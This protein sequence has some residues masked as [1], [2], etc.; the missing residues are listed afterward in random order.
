MKTVLSVC[1]ALAASLLVSA[2]GGTE[3]DCVRSA[4]MSKTDNLEIVVG[5]NSE[6]VQCAPEEFVGLKTLPSAPIQ[7]PRQSNTAEATLKQGS[8]PSCPN[9]PKDGTTPSGA[10]G[11]GSSDAL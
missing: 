6:D 8:T 1:A 2:C 11:A 10:G 9:C 4:A 7:V 5:D 3:A